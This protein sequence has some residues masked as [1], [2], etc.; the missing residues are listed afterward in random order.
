MDADE[1]E[2]RIAAF[3]RWNYRITFENGVTT[4]VP[5]HGQANRHEQRR[6]YFFDRLLHLAGG[7]LEGRRVLDLGCNAGLW[8]LNALEAGAA[9]VT[10]IDARASFVQQ[11][12]LVFEAKGIDPSRFS[13][14]HGNVFEHPIEGGYD[15]VLCLGVMEVTSRPVEL[16]E[17]M[18][19]TGA[20]LIVIDTGV[21]RARSSFFEVDA[22]TDPDAVVD[23]ALALVPT[24]E[25]VVELA[26]QFGL[27]AVELEQ[28]ITDYAGLDDYRRGRRTAFICSSAVA[29]DSLP[30]AAARRPT[31]RLPGR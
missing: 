15:V 13:F 12:E 18:T 19:R 8:S 20:E 17:I 31:L 28:N 14:E 6:R 29:L 30:A 4:P 24:R 2:D 21:S 23:Y 5:D 3:P 11:A 22:I 27:R 10:G 16:F 25:A 9:F 7:T 26:A 1:L